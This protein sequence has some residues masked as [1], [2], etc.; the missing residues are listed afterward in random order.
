MHRKLRRYF[1]QVV[2]GF[3]V[4]FLFVGLSV[5]NSQAAEY[6]SNSKIGFYGKWEPPGP[7]KPDGKV[8]DIVPENPNQDIMNPDKSVTSQKVF[9]KTGED[10]SNFWWMGVILILMASILWHLK[11]EKNKYEKV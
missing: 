2:L 1:F 5:Q 10:F 9:P 11:K 4:G 6:V 3:L 7:S 8:P